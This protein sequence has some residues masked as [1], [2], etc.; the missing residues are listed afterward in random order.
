V[1]AP[2][3]PAPVAK[4]APVE[5]PPPVVVAAPVVALGA[6]CPNHISVRSKVAYPAQAELRGLNGDVLIEFT[7][8]GNGNVGSAHVVKSSDPIFEDAALKAVTEHLHCVGQGQDVRV[9]IPFSFRH[10]N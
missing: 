8:A 2:I 7:V 4:A 1:P 5:A 6:A 9:R 10:G 3:A